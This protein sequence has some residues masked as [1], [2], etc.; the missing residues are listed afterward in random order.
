MAEVFLK[1]LI[2]GLQHLK[3]VS[4]TI[5]V[6]IINIEWCRGMNDQNKLETAW[7]NTLSEKYYPKVNLGDVPQTFEDIMALLRNI[8]SPSGIFLAN[9]V[10]E[11][12]V[13]FSYKDNTT[14]YP[15]KDKKM[16]NH[17]LIF[18]SA[19]TSTHTENTKEGPFYKDFAVDMTFVWNILH[20]VF[21]GT[22]VWLHAKTSPKSNN[23]RYAFF[24]INKFLLGS[25]Y[26]TH[27]AAQLKLKLK[28]RRFYYD[29]E[30]RGFSFQKFVNFHKGQH[31][32]ADG[33]MEFGYIRIDDNSKV[34]MLR[35]GINTDA[36]EAY[37]AA[38]LDS[39]EM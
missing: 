21:G 11:L 12:L 32:I 15:T 7:T 20:H 2:W 26:V 5:D 16:I 28:L 30:R 4:R 6:D 37:K 31:I 39:P 29:G 25:Q 1:I 27:M 38:I 35:G 19:A 36:I 17:A 22:T 8:C 18:T 3:L 9:C 10:R 24:L 13:P 34:R 14:N 33:F 23:W